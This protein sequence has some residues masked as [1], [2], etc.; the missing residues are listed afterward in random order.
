MYN[1]FLKDQFIILYPAIERIAKEVPKEKKS[2]T[3]F[4]AGSS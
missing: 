4:C 2:P 1:D 3:H